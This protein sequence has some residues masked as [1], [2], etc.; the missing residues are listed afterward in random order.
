MTDTATN[1]V[2][3]FHATGL[4]PDDY[5]ASVG[6]LHA[7]GQ[8][9]PTTG[10][11]TALL[12]A[13]NAPGFNFS[14]PHGVSFTA[15]PPPAVT[16]VD[17]ISTFAVAPA[18]DT[19]PDS[20]TLANGDT[21]VAY[22]NGADST[23]KSGHST[24]VQYDHSGHI[25]HSYQIAGYVDG[26]K[27]DP[28]T[29]EIWALQNQDG[30]STLSI[31]HPDDQSVGQP[32]SYA[33]PSSTQGYDDV[34]FTHGQVFMSHTNP[35]NPGDPTL[36]QVTNANDLN[37]G[38]LTTK[39][40]L[41]FGDTGLNLETGKTE[42]IPQNDP[43]S[44][45]LAPNGDLLLSSGAD[46]VIIDVHDAGTSQQS[47]AFTKVQGVPAGAGLDDVLKVDASA[48]T[49]YLS[50][51]ADNRVLTVH[52]TGLNTNDY[53]ASVGN[54]FGEVD[55]N[56]GKFTA[57]VSADNAPGFKFGSAH[58]AEFVA[59]QSSQPVAHQNGPSVSVNSGNDGF[60]FANSGNSAGNVINSDPHPAPQGNSPAQALSQLAAELPPVAPSGV[61]FQH[62]TSLIHGTSPDLQ[63]FH[64]V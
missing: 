52:A 23:G 39:A 1:K 56:T 2:Y 58:G 53:F 18:G 48:G 47:V 19:A 64:L 62:D 46:Q 29:G 15:D 41:D 35:A 40:I 7:F 30:N 61:D 42:V 49:F 25:D 12:S 10:A 44:L 21:W 26:L 31:I 54:A 37:G 51:T 38:P 57:L 27:F 4:N 63:A 13:D 33:N 24:I 43:D 50:D 20:I 6:S 45:K 60:T 59:D 55:P 8:V 9:D 11:F 17:H 16:K 3:T 5:Y 22:T 14:S 34:V 32:L 28:Y 36:V